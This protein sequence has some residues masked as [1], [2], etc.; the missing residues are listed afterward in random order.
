MI[1]AALALHEL[2][3]DDPLGILA[4][5]GGLEIAGLVGAMLAAAA[6]GIPV[7]LDGFITGRRRSSRRASPRICRIAWWPR[8]APWSPAMRSFRAARLRPILQLD[9]RL[10]EGSGAALAI[11][12]IRAAAR[13]C[14][15]M[16]T[17][18]EAGVS[19]PADRRPRIR[20]S[21]ADAH[22][23]LRPRTI[24]RPLGV[25]RPHL[26]C[27]SDVEGW[28]WPT[29]WPWPTTRRRRCGRPPPGLHGGAG[30]PAPAREIAS[31][32]DDDRADD[33]LVFAGA[34]EAIFC[35]SNVLLGPGRPCRRHVA[36]LPEPVRGRPGRRRRRHPPRA[37]RGRR[38]GARCRPAH[39]VRSGRTT[40]LVVVNAPHNPTGMLPTA[41]TGR[42]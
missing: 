14:G 18:A 12:I 26:L 33:V 5:V 36:R 41:P 13:I 42:A 34:E 40:R 23:R 17:F 2:D 11:P 29:C 8:T 39:R 38:L 32:Y 30:P 24:L 1:D 19:G 20:R 3:P 22:R 16:A 27:A 28:P 6:A 10:G 4:A 37:A 15:E 9:L 25:R 21:S 35:L 7:V 31:L